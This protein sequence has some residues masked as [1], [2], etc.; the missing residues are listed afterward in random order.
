MGNLG[1]DGGL[2]ACAEGRLTVVHHR[3]IV[4]RN[5]KG[6]GNCVVVRV[7]VVLFS[8]KTKRIR[9]NAIISFYSTFK[10]SM[11]KHQCVYTDI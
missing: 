7:E 2:R 1:D 8:F 11:I 6:A 10:R 3:A 9:A 5:P 4:I